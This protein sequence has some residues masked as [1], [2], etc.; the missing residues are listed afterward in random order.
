[1]VAVA[2]G[3]VETA[4]DT[5]ILVIQID[6]DVSVES[7]IGRE[8]LLLSC[9]MRTHKTAKNLGHCGTGGFDLALS[10]RARAKD[11]WDADGCHRK[12]SLV[13][14]GAEGFVVG[15]DTHLIV[16]YPTRIA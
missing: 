2:D 16:R 11:W 6:V 5:H 14:V 1:M 4:E 12:R 10:S 9:R 3:G 8:Q 7:P 15:E 13:G